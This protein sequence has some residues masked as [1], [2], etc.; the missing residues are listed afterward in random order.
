VFKHALLTHQ[1]AKQAKGLSPQCKCNAQERKGWM[2]EAQRI[3]PKKANVQEVS[4]FA[5]KQET[6]WKMC[7]G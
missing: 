7:H 6:K 1:T 3:R 5:V 4:W 2:I